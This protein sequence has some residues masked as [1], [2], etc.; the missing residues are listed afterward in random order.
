MM[1]SFGPGVELPFLLFSVVKFKKLPKAG[2]LMN[3]IKYSFGFMLLYLVYI[4]LEKDIGVLG[5][6][7][8]ATLSLA[9][10]I[11]LNLWDRLLTLYGIDVPDGETAC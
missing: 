4:S 10:D 6:E 2:Y 7:S 9:V 5:V 1:V 3:K 8:S 11:T